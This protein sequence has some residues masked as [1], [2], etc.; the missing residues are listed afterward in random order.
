MSPKLKCRQNWNVTKI[1]M[2]LE[3]KCH[4]N[5]Y[6]TKT[7][8]SPK[9]KC[10]QNWNVPKTKILSKLIY[11]QNL[12]VTKTNSG[13]WPWLPWPCSVNYYA[14]LEMKGLEDFF[15]GS[16]NG[17]LAFAKSSLKY[18]DGQTLFSWE[19]RP[20]LKCEDTRE[21]CCKFCVH[22]LSLS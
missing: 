20:R 13:D 15:W 6:V 9:L 18:P 17:C 21:V 22:C 11:H 2:S 14:A 1:E 10:H 16:K 19:Y 12:N 3:V 5:W 7:E 4:Q 8:M